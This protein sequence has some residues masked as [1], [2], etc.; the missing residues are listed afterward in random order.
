MAD[1]AARIAAL[2]EALA[3]GELRIRVEG[4]E[5]E[6]RDTS[7]LMRALA[8]FKGQQQTGSQAGGRFATTL[9]TWGEG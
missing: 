5:T 2:E 6:Y 7:S 9:A 3:S 8:Y 1:H 4:K